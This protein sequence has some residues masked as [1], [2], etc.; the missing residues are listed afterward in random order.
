M[1]RQLGF[2][3][4]DLVVELG[5]SDHAAGNGPERGCDSRRGGELLGAQ[6]G[7]DIERLGIGVTLSPSTFES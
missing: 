6:S 3:L 1:C 7:L 2:E 5:D 4:S